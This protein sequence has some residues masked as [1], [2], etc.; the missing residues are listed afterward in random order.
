[1]AGYLV[2]VGESV[3]AASF[4]FVSPDRSF[5]ARV[6]ELLVEEEEVVANDSPSFPAF[7]RVGSSGV[8]FEAT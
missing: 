5:G 3:A 7:P 2:Q 1:M 8:A 6:A 4:D